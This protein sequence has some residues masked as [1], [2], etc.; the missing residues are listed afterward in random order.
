LVRSIDASGDCN[1]VRAPVIDDVAVKAF[2]EAIR[3]AQLDALEAI[4]QEQQQ[5]R[6]R[7]E[8]HWQEQ[9]KRVRYAAQLAQ[10]QYDAV[11]PDNRLVA[12]ELERRWEEQL[13][14]LRQTEEAYHH[15]Q[16]TPLPVG[17][18]PELQ[19]QFR[20]VSRHLPELW[21]SLKN[22]HKKQLLR[23]LISQV[24]IRRA[25]PDQIQLRIVWVSGFY[26]DYEAW[27]P[28]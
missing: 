14:Q 12:A 26:T 10:R 23:S 20:E 17:V 3:P 2:F 5:E 8:R 18:P 4:L 7:L 28:I 25:A 6:Q 11:D 19:E 21:P 15:F 13:Q 24:I 1:S 16:Q 27:T 22:A 9:L